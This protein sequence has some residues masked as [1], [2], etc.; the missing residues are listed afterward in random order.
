[1]T[2]PTRCPAEVRAA[3][4]L[5]LRR[6]ALVACHQPRTVVEHA[7]GRRRLA[8][9]ELLLLQR[10]LLRHRRAVEQRVTASA[11]EP[12]GDL[13]GAG[14][15]ALPFALT[16]AQRRAAEAIDADLRRTIPM[17]RLLQGDVGSGKTAVA[18][19]ALLRAVDSGRQGALMAPTETLATQH[20]VNVVRHLRRARRAGRGAHQRHARAGAAGA[21]CS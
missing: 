21:R 17:R 7:L 12:A 14:L 9:D 18:V 13:V 5:P 1:M 11:L 3:R 19:Y 10:G 6:D 8:Y 20:L 4:K 2:G 15:A 16:G